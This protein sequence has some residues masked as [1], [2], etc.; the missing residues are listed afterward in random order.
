[1]GARGAVYGTAVDR[2]V[3]L[4]GGPYQSATATRSLRRTLRP[5]YAGRQSRDRV[6]VVER[7]RPK[8]SP[9]TPGIALRLASSSCEGSHH[10][11]ATNSSTELPASAGAYVVE[12]LGQ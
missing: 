9:V 2:N 10:C 11:R 12:V 3:R 7:N 4:N 6:G 8:T 1:M 5:S